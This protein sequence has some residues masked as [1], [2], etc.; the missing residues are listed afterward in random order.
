MCDPRDKSQNCQYCGK[1]LTRIGV[2]RKNG[3]QSHDDWT[4]RKYHKKCLVAKTTEMFAKDSE[5]EFSKIYTNK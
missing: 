4:N 3:K 2:S 5:R 1:V